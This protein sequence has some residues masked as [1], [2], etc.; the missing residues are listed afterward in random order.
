[1]FHTEIPEGVYFTIFGSFQAFSK[2]EWVSETSWSKN[3]AYRP[4]RNTPDPW[5]GSKNTIFGITRTFATFWFRNVS[6]Q[7]SPNDRILSLSCVCW[8]TE[9]TGK[10]LGEFRVTNSILG[11]C[12]LSS[13]TSVSDQILTPWP[14]FEARKCGNNQPN[15]FKPVL[16]SHFWCFL[17]KTGFG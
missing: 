4:F 10:H 8:V 7:E 16:P 17:D 9:L 1:M 11:L 12:E 14:A 3:N 13:L 2:P 5:F 6:E 15:C